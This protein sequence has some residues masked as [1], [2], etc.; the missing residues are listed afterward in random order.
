M[1][2]DR[3]RPPR[4]RPLRRYGQNH[5]VD[6]GVLGAILRQAA[7]RPDDVVLEVG[8]ADGLLTRPLLETARVV[9]AFEVDRRYAPRLERLAAAPGL[10]VHLEDALRTRLADLDPPPTMMAANL[11]YNIAIPLIMTTLTETPSIGRWAVMVQRELG[12]RLFAAPRTK[13][14]AAVSVLTQLACE[15]EKTRP[16][17]RSAFRPRP[18]VD[19]AFVTFTRRVAAEDGSWAVGAERLDAA[20][21]AAVGALVRRAFAQRRKQLVTSLAGSAPAGAALATSLT[22]SAPAGVALAGSPAKDAPLV[23]SQ[24]EAVAPGGGETIAPPPGA[25]ADSGSPGAGARVSLARAEIARALEVVGAVVTARPDELE[26]ER[27]IAFARALGALPP[28]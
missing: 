27:W 25:L 15:L 28:S 6:R 5:L 23:T 4:P 20:G 26:P 13:A 22:G 17:A 3:D 11:A 7:V 2:A 10:I 18:N 24:Q 8:A 19:S 14:Y 9:H 21:F 12:E 16:V 1:P